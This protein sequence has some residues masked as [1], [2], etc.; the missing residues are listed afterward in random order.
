MGH[1]HVL[2]QLIHV[3]AYLQQQ[4]QQLTH[5]QQLQLLPIAVLTALVIIFSYH[6][7]LLQV[8][9]MSGKIL[10]VL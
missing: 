7:L 8:Q 9:H 4:L 2:L 5:I 3:Q 6:L 10:L 1:I